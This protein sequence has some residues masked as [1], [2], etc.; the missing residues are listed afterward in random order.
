[1]R[2]LVALLVSCLVAWIAHAE[3]ALAEGRLA[4][5][6]REVEESPDPKPSR[7]TPT[8]S[9]SRHA[10][11]Y[12]SH[13]RPRRYYRPPPAYPP[14]GCG[15]SCAA[16]VYAPNGLYVDESAPIPPNLPETYASFPYASPHRSYMLEPDLRLWAA[17][18]AGTMG[19]AGAPS[20]AVG[21][22]WA[23]R[24]TLDTGYL[25]GVMHG[26]LGARLLTPSRFEF[27]VR[28]ALMYEPSVRDRAQLLGLELAMRLLQFDA[29]MVRLFAAV[30]NFDQGGLNQYG[31]ELGIDADLF[32][33]RP[34]VVSLRGSGAYLGD[35]FVSTL[36]VQLGYLFERYE[37]FVG[38]QD[39][40]I[41]AVN[42]STPLLGTRIWL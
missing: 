20:D 16:L 15:P 32:V 26:S 6:R 2:Q 17:P 36:R 28:G 22:A 8:Q 7:S 23:G 25:L 42:L 31:G 18:D 3:S 12:E 40:R 37:L 27:A 38:Y 11:D 30:Q 13:P 34:W 39:F 1:V 4:R 24:L 21:R 5:A 9:R 10:H 14:P 33:G 41:G 19:S 29:L 35:A